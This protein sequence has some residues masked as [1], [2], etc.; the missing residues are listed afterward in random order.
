MDNVW[1]TEIQQFLRLFIDYH[2]I[3]VSVYS[4]YHQ[5]YIPFEIYWNLAHFEQL[6]ASDLY[7]SYTPFTPK[8]LIAVQTESISIVTIPDDCDL[9]RIFGNYYQ[10]FE[11]EVANNLEYF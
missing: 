11:D 7:T 4:G 10:D 5:V 3:G 1:N 9:D 8:I 2:P 6:P